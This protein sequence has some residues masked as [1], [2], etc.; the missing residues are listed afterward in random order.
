MA[1]RNTDT[2]QVQLGEPMITPIIL[3]FS[4]GMWLFRGPDITQRQLHCSSS[5]QPT[6][7]AVHKSL[8][9]RV[10]RTTS[11]QQVKVFFLGNSV[12]LSLLQATQLSLF[13]LDSLPF[14]RGP[15]NS[16]YCLN[17]LGEGEI[18]SESGQFQGFLQ[19]LCCLVSK[20]NTFLIRMECFT[21]N[22]S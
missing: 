4:I 1:D 17:I 9:C 13:L 18:I 16:S 8:K 3:G 2:I 21:S 15:L 14:L 20:I 10:H 12:G 7:V 11:A 5:L 6:W 22:N 19:P